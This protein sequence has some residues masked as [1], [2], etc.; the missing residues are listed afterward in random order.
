M[1]SILHHGCCNWREELGIS[2]IRENSCSFQWCSFH[3]FWPTILSFK[4]LNNG[5]SPYRE[6]PLCTECRRDQRRDVDGLDEKA[7]SPSN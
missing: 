5:S 6:S 3:Y 4:P 1:A 7:D 2:N